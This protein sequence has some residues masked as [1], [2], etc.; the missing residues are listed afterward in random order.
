M[1]LVKWNNGHVTYA[2]GAFHDWKALWNQVIK[3]LPKY[4]QDHAKFTEMEIRW[5]IIPSN[6]DNRINLCGHSLLHHAKTKC[7]SV[8]YISSSCSPIC[9]REGCL[10]YQ[11]VKIGAILRVRHLWLLGSFYWWPKSLW[12]HMQSLP[13]REKGAYMNSDPAW[14]WPRAS[15]TKEIFTE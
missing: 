6:C 9:S 12:R 7:C 8:L 15:S 5:K 2:H 3:R 1:L 10:S 4:T 13:P 14:L 11:I